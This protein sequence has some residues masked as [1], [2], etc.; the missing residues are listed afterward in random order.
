MLSVA[1]SAD[2]ECR[3]DGSVYMNVLFTG[4]SLQLTTDSARLAVDSTACDTVTFTT[5]SGMVIQGLGRDSI[6]YGGGAISKAYLP[7]RPD[8]TLT[9]YVLQYN[10]LFDTLYV[11]HQNDLRFIS[12]ACGCFVFH[13]ID[14][15]YAAGTF[16]DSAVIINTAVSTVNEEHLRVY[17]HK[18]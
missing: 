18:R 6:L 11:L 1:C 4:D 15:A 17:F 2:K 14:S 16:I 7:L 13:T 10:G 5:V 3:Q 12:L 8:T 9:A